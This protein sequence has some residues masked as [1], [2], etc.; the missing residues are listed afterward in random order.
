MGFR[1]LFQFCRWGKN[2]EMEAQF[3]SITG[4]Y[5]DANELDVQVRTA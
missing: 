1:E 2:E 3:G 4:W 5:L